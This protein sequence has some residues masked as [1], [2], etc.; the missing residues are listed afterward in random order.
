MSKMI[1]P[2]KLELVRKELA[3]ISHWENGFVIP[4]QIPET[5][6]ANGKDNHYHIIGVRLSDIGPDKEKV[7]RGKHI[8]I[9]INQYNRIQRQIKDKSLKQMFGGTWH[10]TYILHN[11]T[12]KAKVKGLSPKAK[13]DIKKL[14]EDGKNSTDIANELGADL[15]QVRAYINKLNK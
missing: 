12:E 4:T 14:K 1:P 13:G 3:T 5:K 6:D 11:P 15:D 8:C 9:S 2:N 10:R 7:H